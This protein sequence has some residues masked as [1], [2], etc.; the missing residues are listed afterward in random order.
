VQGS[1]N[2]LSS[3]RSA[4]RQFKHN[5]SSAKDMIDTIYN[6]LDQDTESTVGVLREVAGLFEDEEKSR[7]V[8]EAVNAF[9][10]TVSPRSIPLP[11]DTETCS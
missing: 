2:K 6:V 8:L 1:D 4:V 7:T 9:R 10:I 3:F 5:E 11:I